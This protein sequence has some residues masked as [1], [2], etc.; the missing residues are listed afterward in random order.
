MIIVYANNRYIVKNVESIRSQHSEKKVVFRNAVSYMGEIEPCDQVIVIGDFPKVVS[1][2]SKVDGV[3][4][5]AME[6][7]SDVHTQVK[8]E[9]SQRKKE[10]SIA[11]EVNDEK[12]AQELVAA[13]KT[14][15]RKTNGN[16]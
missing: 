2:Y 13:S 14:R 6:E 1:A 3:E 9:D 12:A 10:E 11:A 5:T 16:D 8:N 7:Q 15:I 4:V